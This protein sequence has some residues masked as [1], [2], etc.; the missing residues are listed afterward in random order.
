MKLDCSVPILVVF[1]M[2][3]TTFRF[4]RMACQHNKKGDARSWCHHVKAVWVLPVETEGKNNEE[5]CC[6]P[7]IRCISF[8]VIARFVCIL[9]MTNLYRIVVFR[10]SC[11]ELYGL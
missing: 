4:S 7:S 3:N 2:S 10:I 8:I 11:D 1:Q 5:W 9:G 6:F